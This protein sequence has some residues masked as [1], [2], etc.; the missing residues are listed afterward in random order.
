[1]AAAVRAAHLAPDDEDQM[2][3]YFA[4]AATHLI[5]QDR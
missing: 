1:M 2:L 5:N 4:M 3:T